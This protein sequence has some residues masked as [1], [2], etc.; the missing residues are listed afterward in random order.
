MLIF[1]KVLPTCCCVEHKGYV[2]VQAAPKWIFPKVLHARFP[3]LAVNDCDNLASLDPTKQPL[4]VLLG[5]TYTFAQQIMDV[6]EAFGLVIFI[7][8]KY[9]RDAFCIDEFNDFRRQNITTNGC[10]VA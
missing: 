5:L 1:Q 2:P 6:D 4:A 10:R 8:D 3:Q 9:S 7:D